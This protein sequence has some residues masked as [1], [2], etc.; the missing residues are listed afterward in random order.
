MKIR[1]LSSNA[2][3]NSFKTLFTLIASFIT[4]AY[5]TRL[6]TVAD[7]GRLHFGESVISYFMLVADLGIGIFA[8]RAG[9]G[10]RGDEN[11]LELFSSRMF[12]VSLISTA[13]SIVLLILLVSFPS[14]IAEYRTVIL[15]QSVTVLL[16][17]FA[18]EWVFTIY[19]D[20]SFIALRSIFARLLSLTLLFVFV[21]D[22]SDFYLYLVLDSAVT[23]LGDI[24]GFLYSRRFLRVK[25]ARDVR[26]REYGKPV[27][28]IFL[29]N[30]TATVYVHADTVM[31]GLMCGDAPVAVYGVATKV[32]FTVKNLFNAALSVTVPRISALWNEDKEKMQD[33]ASD[34]LSLSVIFAVPAAVG[35]VLLKDDIIRLIAGSAYSA[36][37]L[38]LAFLAVALIFSVL[39][40]VLSKNLLIVLGQEKNATEITLVSAVLN[41]ALN[42]VFI[43]AF[44]YAGAAF[45]TIIAEMTVFVGS[46]IV[47]R[48]YLKGL[49]HVRD[50]FD[51]AAGCIVM[52][53]AVSLILTLIPDGM[54]FLR[55]VCGIAA[56]VASYCL[57]LLL[58]RDRMMTAI[59]EKIIHG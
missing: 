33:L 29:Y 28:T 2:L 17:P 21:R 32:Y 8:V 50:I 20:F 15:I 7:I 39:A 6:F 59:F 57:T 58:L 22:A 43:P 9:S 44:S 40:T 16:A 55:L 23:G 10:M 11:A 14:G 35:I 19:E 18:V 26:W 24:A 41:V 31:L 46:L 13:V 45:T 42:L 51:A 53:I 3:L 52:A 34:I 1:S 27:M 5:I 30:L 54:L 49:F 56:G 38:P 48:R 47:V 36:S 12:T 4:Y 25:P 37:A